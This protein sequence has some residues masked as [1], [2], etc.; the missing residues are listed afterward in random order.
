M[1]IIDSKHEDLVDSILERIAEKTY[2]DFRIE[3]IDNGDL[4]IKFVN[5][6]GSTDYN[7]I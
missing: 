4:I 6:E 2:L 1:I 5:D 3:K 7:Q